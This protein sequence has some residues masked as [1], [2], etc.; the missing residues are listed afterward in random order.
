MSAY[1]KKGSSRSIR[2]IGNEGKRV[3][4]RSGTNEGRGGDN[5]QG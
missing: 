3:K 4:T 5:G 2:R 1:K